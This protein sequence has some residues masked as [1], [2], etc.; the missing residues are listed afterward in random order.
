MAVVLFIS[1]VEND[2]TQVTGPSKEGG[3]Q[4]GTKSADSQNPN[5]ERDEL[6]Q[7]YMPEG[8]IVTSGK[9]LVYPP[10]L[11]S[12]DFGNGYTLKTN[13]NN[14]DIDIT[15]SCGDKTRYVSIEIESANMK[16]ESYLKDL[17][18]AEG[19]LPEIKEG[20]SGWNYY[21]AKGWEKDPK[22]AVS[23]NVSRV[24]FKEKDGNVVD[25]T[26]YDYC[27][28]KYNKEIDRLI[29]GVEFLGRNW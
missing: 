15:K 9:R 3:G 5:K 26:Q 14:R 21:A 25:I 13:V 22:K 23:G 16:Y 24:F 4:N 7:D 19:H 11:I 17:S 20:P 12:I 2:K 1:A 18:G 29:K 28:G 10:A 6:L 27:G 8:T